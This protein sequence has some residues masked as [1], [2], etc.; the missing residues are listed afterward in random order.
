MFVCV[1]LLI[2]YTQV[3]PRSRNILSGAM[4]GQK[5]VKQTYIHTHTHTHTI[6]L[7]VAVR[8]EASDAHVV[9]FVRDEGGVAHV[10]I[11]SPLGVSL[12]AA[13]G[14]GR[15]GDS[16]LFFCSLCRDSGKGE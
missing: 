7:I 1:P 8:D 12:A 13:F 14:V 15:S 2:A 11:R 3:P 16:Q 6:E 5:R 10:V 4:K 9:G